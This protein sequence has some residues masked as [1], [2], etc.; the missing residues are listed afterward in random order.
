MMGFMM[1]DLPSSPSEISKQPQGLLLAPVFR[2]GAWTN[3]V[4]E[5]R[6]AEYQYWT[7]GHIL[8]TGLIDPDSDSPLTWSNLNQFLAFYRSVL[9]RE[10]NSIYEQAIADRYVAYLQASQ[11]PLSEPLLVPEL[12]Y[13]GIEPKHLYR[14][15]F[16]VFNSHTMELTGFELS[17]ASTHMAVSGIL[18]EKKT[19]ADMNR[20]LAENWGNEMAKRNQYFETFGI[21][22]VTFTDTKLKDMDACFRQV[23]SKLA[24]RNNLTADYSDAL[25]RLD[26]YRF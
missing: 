22:T 5:I 19:Q 26:S 16:T 6:R 14:L 4:S 18:K 1:L 23:Q 7:I 17:P 24:A 11:S 20:E 15:D 2:R 12:R 3:D 10:S 25:K 13:G 21:P 9:K 8:K